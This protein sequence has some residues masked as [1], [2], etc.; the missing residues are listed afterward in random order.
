MTAGGS[1]SSGSRI[2]STAYVAERSGEVVGFVNVGP[3]F[4]S[5]ELGQ[6]YAIYVVPHA[7]G[8]AR[9]RR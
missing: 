6:L 5:P 4:S 3:C 1:G 7:Q 2:R 9:V 8:S